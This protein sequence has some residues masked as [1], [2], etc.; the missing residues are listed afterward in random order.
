MINLLLV[1]CDPQANIAGPDHSQSDSQA[2]EQ[3]KA[4][5]RAAMEFLDNFHEYDTRSVATRILYHLQKWAEE[6]DPDPDWIADPLFRRLPTRFDAMQG[7]AVLSRLAFQNFDIMMLREALWARDLARQVRDAPLHDVR[8]QRWLDGQSDKLSA[9]SVYDLQVALKICDW[10]VRNIEQTPIIAG[11]G[12]PAPG[13]AILPG[14]S[15]LIG[16][17]DWMVK[18][19]VA[20]LMGRQL[21]IPLTMLAIEPED[22]EPVPWCLSILI[23]GE[24]FLFD[25]RLGLPLPTREG[26]GVITLKSL[27][28]DPSRIASWEA[29]AEW[30]YPVQPPDL[31]RVVAVIEATP[32][33]LSQRMKLV[34]SERSGDDLV[35]LTI[36][37]S[38]LG[39]ELRKC[40]GIGSNISL[41]TV[42]YDAYLYRQQLEAMPAFFAEL[43]AKLNLVDGP[44]PLAAARRQHFRGIYA[45]TDD[46]EGAKQYYMTCRIPDAELARLADDKKFAESLGIMEQLPQDPAVRAAFLERTRM[47]MLKSK[48]YASYWLGLIAFEQGN[49]QVASDF[50][51]KRVLQSAD[52]NPWRVGAR[53]N[54][55]RCREQQALLEDDA[56]MLTRAIALYE[57]DQENP[58]ADG[59][60]LRA[61]NLRLVKLDQ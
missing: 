51:E 20:T 5:F 42:P 18:S 4:D 53:Y 14:E 2:A 48:Q 10:V 38:A 30:T 8:L 43:Q 33:Y 49:Y 31:K 26:T 9:D 17:G 55:A 1:G 16:E 3:A 57:Q 21:G 54:L 11:E 22:A 23:D 34:E 36:T 35:T 27:I 24:L 58:Q 40:A 60:R 39:T 52:E 7:E 32:A 45:D 25:M 28:D 56:D 46:E 41:W 37:P 12:L 29:A 59:N 15:L 47:T 19:R 6:Q 44:T 13:A 61:A 50:F